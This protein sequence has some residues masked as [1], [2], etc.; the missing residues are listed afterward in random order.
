MN[1]ITI[2]IGANNDSNQVAQDY[3]KGLNINLYDKFVRKQTK[4]IS[5]LE[6]KIKSKQRS[7]SLVTDINS[8]KKEM[9]FESIERTIDEILEMEIQLSVLKENLKNHIQ[10]TFDKYFKKEDKKKG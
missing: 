4:E 3:A 9:S 6:M 1:I 8:G 5:D 7:I 2:L 10:P